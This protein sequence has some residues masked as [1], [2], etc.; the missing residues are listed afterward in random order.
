MNTKIRLLILTIF[1]TFSISCAI[2]TG[3]KISRIRPDMS[4]NEVIK[5]LGNPDG[6]KTNE[7]Y[8]A[9][10]YSH[11]L[12]SGWAY[13]RADYSIILKDD[14]VIEYGMGEVRVKNPN[15]SVLLLVPIK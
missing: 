2:T 5:I 4:K 10:I 3:E 8:Q 14:K 11:R 7:D 15:S 13:D 1:M 6:F 9:L 12:V